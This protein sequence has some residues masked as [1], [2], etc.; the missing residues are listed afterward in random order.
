MPSGELLRA[1]M[2]PLPLLMALLKLALGLSG[3]VQRM[4]RHGD[5]GVPTHTS[6]LEVLNG[7]LAL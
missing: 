2:P 7:V 3:V 4:V 5:M 1:A 6:M